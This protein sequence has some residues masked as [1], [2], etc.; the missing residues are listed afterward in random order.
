MKNKTTHTKTKMIENHGETVANSDNQTPNN[1]NIG[2]KL[3]KM[4]DSL[5]I[6]LNDVAKE[7]GVSASFLSMVENNKS[8]ISFSNLQKVLQFYNLNISDLFNQEK[9]GKE[10]RVVYA[11]QAKE[12]AIKSD[13]VTMFLLSNIISER[14]MQPCL[15]IVQPGSLIGYMKHQGEEFAYIIKGYFAFDLRDP[16]TGREEHYH[17]AEGDTI[18]YPS[19]ME[20]RFINIS[21][22]PGIFLAA[23]TPPTF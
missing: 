5:G 18:Y 19:T 9:Y 7:V 16:E 8:G 22:K 21:N 10:S 12:V 20:H 3:R 4:R 1:Y 15:F 13:G 11:K 2:E 17:L 14:K 6:T 23:V